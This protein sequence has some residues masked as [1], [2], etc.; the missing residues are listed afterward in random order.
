GRAVRHW[1]SSWQ[2]HT[3]QATCSAAREELPAA[4]HG[5]GDVQCGTGRAPGS[6]TRR[7]GRAVR[8]WKSS[9]QPHTAQGTCSAPLEELPAA[10]GIRRLVTCVSGASVAWPSVCRLLA[11]ARCCLGAAPNF[12]T[13]AQLPQKHCMAQVFVKHAVG[14]VTAFWGAPDALED[15]AE[16]A[17]ECSQQIRAQIKALNKKW[18]LDGVPD[19]AIR[20]GINTGEV[21]CG[22]VGSAQKLKFGILGDEVSFASRLQ[23][24]NKRWNTHAVCSAATFQHVQA[25]YVGRPLET[26]IVKGRESTLVHEI[27]CRVGEETSQQ[28]YLQK[29]FTEIFQLY[30]SRQFN[31]VLDLCLQ[32]DARLVKPDPAA[33]IM[34][35]NARH[36]LQNPPASDWNGGSLTAEK[37][38]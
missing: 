18:V 9:W 26:V 23:N 22:N 24:L 6:P 34:A 28:K 4:P 8:H 35:Q 1:K 15:H 10:V 21:F 7:R 13:Q 14:C 29:T 38:G 32:V 16:R 17:V 12:P 30:K 11:C 37:Y 27:I 19:V 33:A 36:L 31:A 25:S 20:I 3:A 2:P 5:T